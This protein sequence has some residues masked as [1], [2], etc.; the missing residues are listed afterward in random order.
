MLRSQDQ[1]GVDE[2]MFYLVK[3]NVV[4]CDPFQKVDGVMSNGNLGNTTSSSKARAALAIFTSI[5]PEDKLRF[6]KTTDTF[7]IDRGGRNFARSFSN[8]FR[9]SGTENSVTNSEMFRTPIVMI[10][11]IA[12]ITSTDD[13]LNGAYTGLLNLRQTYNNERAKLE[14][15]NKMLQEVRQAID[16]PLK[17]S[18]NSLLMLSQEL[19]QKAISIFSQYSLLADALVAN[20]IAQ[21]MSPVDKAA[22]RVIFGAVRKGDSALSNE[23]VKIG[24]Y[25]DFFLKKV[26]EPKDDEFQVGRISRLVYD[27]LQSVEKSMVQQY[28]N[29]YEIWISLLKAAVRTSQ[30][31]TFFQV[32]DGKKLPGVS[33]N[34]NMDAHPKNGFLWFTREVFP[35]NISRLYFCP[36]NMYE[37]NR[38]VV[39]A[40]DILSLG[41]FSFKFKIDYNKEMVFGR[42]DA[43]VLYY[44]GGLDQG[45][46]LAELFKTNL[47]GYFK[48][49]M[50]PFNST[51]VS[52]DNDIF[53]QKEPER[54]NTGLNK[55]ED[56]HV[57]GFDD[58]GNRIDI[59]QD[60]R[61][62]SASS[63]R[64][65]LITM[66]LLKWK[67]DFDY[68]VAKC[69][70]S[71]LDVPDLHNDRT[72]EYEFEMF[73]S[74]VA[75]AL[76][77]HRQ[78]I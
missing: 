58:N 73:Q 22:L 13:E 28:S 21:Q 42:R 61:L 10:F 3:T 14:E 78:L 7:E 5:V 64:A 50:G 52:P 51:P 70:D 29:K 43:I 38:F 23:L 66:A 68:Q 16:E 67:I 27:I 34:S 1:I 44:V 47:P 60:R 20:A 19:S 26:A 15:L 77:G 54:F 32:S 2:H 57:R 48:P 49:N 74:F 53:F 33:I 4:K 6:H 39:V 71:G 56:N 12:R 41:Q 46:A 40:G 62:H 9:K 17:F 72:Y 36:Q 69:T 45:R 65:E 24:E 18:S 37:V 30:F 55:K 59:R 11:K 35:D 31:E 76:A 75:R 25:L 8:V 63:I